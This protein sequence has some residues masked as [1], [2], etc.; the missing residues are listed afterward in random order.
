[1]CFTCPACAR[2]PRNSALLNYTHTHEQKFRI[3]EL[4]I[5]TI[6]IS[7]KKKYPQ[8]SALTHLDRI[9]SISM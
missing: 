1:M 5:Y 6:Y 4:R 8:F 3:S 2:T 9:V 7:E